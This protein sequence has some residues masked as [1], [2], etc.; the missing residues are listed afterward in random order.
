MNMQE[1]EVVMGWQ[2]M[3]ILYY[4][5]TYGLISKYKE[6]YE[7]FKHRKIHIYEGSF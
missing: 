1:V 3:V 7:V 6:N 5:E 4:G 2:P